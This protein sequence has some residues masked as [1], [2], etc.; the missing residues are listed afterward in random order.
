MLSWLLALALLAPAGFAEA[1]RAAR[2]PHTAPADAA[3]ALQPFH[4]SCRIRFMEINTFALLVS[5]MLVVDA[6]N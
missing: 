6:L 5:A 2:N 1:W 3:A 4:K